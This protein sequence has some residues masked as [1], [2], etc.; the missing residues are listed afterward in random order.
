MVARVPPY[1]SFRALARINRPAGTRMQSV[2]FPRIDQA[3]E[4]AH[5]RLAHDEAVERV[6][7]YGISTLAGFADQ[8]LLG[9][10]DREGWACVVKPD[11]SVGS[12]GL[13]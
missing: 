7:I 10:V 1:A 2:E 12:V 6:F 3:I 11:P 9:G 13:F 8:F 4:W 5:E